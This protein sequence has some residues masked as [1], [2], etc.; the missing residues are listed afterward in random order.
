[1]LVRLGPDEAWDAAHFTRD[2]GNLTL[3]RVVYLPYT[4]ENYASLLCE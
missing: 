3:G 1:M 2:L 4:E